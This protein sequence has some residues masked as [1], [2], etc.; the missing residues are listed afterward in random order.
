MLIDL[1]KDWLQKGYKQTSGIDYFE[2]FAPVARLDTICM[3]I[4]LATQKRWKNHQIDVKSTF[5]SGVLEKEV[6]VE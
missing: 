2:V 4:A 6:F 3:I 5:L 1:R